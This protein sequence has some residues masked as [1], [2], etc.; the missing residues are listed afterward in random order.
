MKNCFEYWYS[1]EVAE[2]LKLKF[3]ED[4]EISMSLSTVKPL[5]AKWLV[6]V[7]QKLERDKRDKDLIKKG[8]SDAGIIDN[9][10]DYE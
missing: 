7:F 9:N 1:G 3:S 5:H 10:A 4:V 6:S 2:Q 8:F